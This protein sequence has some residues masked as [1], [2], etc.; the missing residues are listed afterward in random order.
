M[1]PSC[2]APGERN[3]PGI[4]SILSILGICGVVLLSACS[5]GDTGSSTD[6]MDSS[7]VS[8][9]LLTKDATPDNYSWNTVADV[10]G[11]AGDDLGNQLDAAAAAVTVDPRSCLALV[12]T[13]DS[14]IAELYDHRD[15]TGAIEFLPT[16]ST[17]P[18]VID[19]I[20]S[21]ADDGDT[22][23][24]ANE[25]IT[26][27]D[28]S[29]FTRTRSDGTVTHFRASAQEASMPGADKITVIT[30][31]SNSVT[32]GEELITTIAGTVDGVN[33]RITAAGVA[34]LDVLSDL[35]QKQ[36]TQIAEFMRGQD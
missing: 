3:T 32:P 21:T 15:A 26:A 30:V 18:A 28:C 4:P 33:F 25:T 24:L 13:S 10:I 35:A 20:V 29:D 1:R 9:M 22:A 12:P 14:I 16:D 34:D 5:G 8:S 19:A 36:V 2:A 31:L 27:A 6:A 17:D 23:D 11:D 7:T